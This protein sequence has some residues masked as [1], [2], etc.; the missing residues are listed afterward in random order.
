M[1]FDTD[2]QYLERERRDVRVLMQRV[3]IEYLKAFDPEHLGLCLD[4]GQQISAIDTAMVVDP[5]SRGR[6]PAK[7]FIQVGELM[8]GPSLPRAVVELVVRIE[9]KRGKQLL[10]RVLRD[11]LPY[12]SQVGM[13]IDWHADRNLTVFGLPL[14]GERAAWSN[15]EV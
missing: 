7:N 3:R 14:R 6:K 8:F 4:S 15:S 13:L 9:K 11:G 5:S 2:Q 12:L 1:S 10:L